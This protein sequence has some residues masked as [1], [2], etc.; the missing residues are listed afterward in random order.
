MYLPAS[1]MKKSNK[2]VCFG[3]KPW[4]LCESATGYCYKFDVYFSKSKNDTNPVLGKSA[5]VVLDLVKGLEH[6]KYNI[7]FDNNYTSVP[8]LSALPE[9]RTGAC[10]T[11]RA[12][13]KYYPKDVPAVNVKCKRRG[14]FAWR[15]N[16]SLF[17]LMWKDRKS[18]LFLSSTDQP[19]KGQAVKLKLNMITATKR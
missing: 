7:Y 9:K 18:I 12:N 4:E 13:H 1:A 16:G 11:I 19:S 15:S 8:L 14:T 3:V 17:A 10:E 5:I 6:K 2:P